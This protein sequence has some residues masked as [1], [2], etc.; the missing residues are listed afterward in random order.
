MPF[1]QVP[2]FKPNV[3]PITL[4]AGVL[5]SDGTVSGTHFAS[6]SPGVIGSSINFAPASGSIDPT[7][8]GFTSSV[9]RIKVT[10]AGNTSFQGL[11][12]GADGQQLFI[13]IVAGA[14]QLTLLH[15]NGGTAQAQ[16]LA[17]ADFAYALN[18][19]AQLFYDGGLTQWVLVT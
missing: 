9:G 12:T 15:L 6:P 16:I 1:S 10:L 4:G 5:T 11:P 18:D 2:T 8:A 19:T 3:P 7:I 13:T 17:S 14:F